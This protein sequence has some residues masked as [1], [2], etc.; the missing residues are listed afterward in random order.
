MALVKCPECGRENV[1]DTA[2]CCPECGFGIHDYFIQQRNKQIAE[3]KAVSA[4]QKAKVQKEKEAEELERRL[5]NIKSP[6]EPQKGVYIAGVVGFGMIGALWM[7]LA[8][9]DGFHF[10]K[11]CIAALFLVMAV[12]TRSAYKDAVSDYNLSQTDFRAYQQKII[13]AE[14][15]RKA[16]AA[17]IA[18]EKAKKATAPV[19]CPKCGSTAIATVN[20][21]YS[22]VWGFIGSGKPMNVCQKCGYK[23]DPKKG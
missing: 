6:E 17:R 19:K 15:A 14:N 13:S 12:A 22:L 5:A 10:F 3:E 1:S 7:V 8:L 20:R 18:Y 16:E 21:G 2:Q 23:F 11:F 9:Y 4:A